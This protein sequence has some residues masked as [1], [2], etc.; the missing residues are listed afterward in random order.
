MLPSDSIGNR[1]PFTMRFAVKQIKYNDERLGL[2]YDQIEAQSKEIKALKRSMKKQ[3][4]RLDSSPNRK[5]ERQAKQISALKK[6]T[7]VSLA[8]KTEALETM[9]NSHKEEMYKLVQT[10][11]ELEYRIAKLSK[12]S[13]NPPPTTAQN[14]Q[15]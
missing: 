7:A 4:R 2:A 11:H 14:I 12:H 1:D 15:L 8:E 5:V 13:K 3:E 9:R 10:M 6:M